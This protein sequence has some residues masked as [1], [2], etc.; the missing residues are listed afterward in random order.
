MT[1]PTL[2]L[3]LPS[4]IKKGVARAAKRDG[5]SVNQFVAIAVAEKL[6][7]LETE[8]YFAEKAKHVDHARFKDLMDRP[9]GAL[10][11]PEDIIP[12]EVT[13]FLQ[14]KCP[15]ALPRA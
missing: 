4:H 13:A 7:V 3:R 6:A 9:G 14:E 1:N 12:D 5:T 10:P 2:S 15:E 8:E 11:R